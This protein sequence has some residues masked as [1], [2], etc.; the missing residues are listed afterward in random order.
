VDDV[1]EQAEVGET[2][3]LVPVE[4]DAIEVLWASDR[5]LPG[6]DQ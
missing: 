2:A 6:D 5:T 1:D 4:P 3:P